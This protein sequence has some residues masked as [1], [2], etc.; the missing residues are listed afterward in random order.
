MPCASLHSCCVSTRRRRSPA[1]AL[2]QV[3]AAVLGVP[4][5]PTIKEVAAD[6]TVVKTLVRAALWE[7]QT[8]QVGPLCRVTC[9]A[10]ARLPAPGE[11]GRGRPC[12]QVACCGRVLCVDG[13]AMQ[14]PLATHSRPAL[15]PHEPV[16]RR[17]AYPARAHTACPLLP[18]PRQVIRPPLLR[19]GFELVRA[20]GL[21]VTDDVSIIEALGEPVR[22]TPGSYTNIKVRAAAAQPQPSTA[23]SSL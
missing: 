13:Q 12:R 7:V 4:V 16:T 6:R 5:K 3:G 14:R 9:Q 22:I 15:Q 2:H 21:E 1:P 19:E 20:Q 17:P 18:R 23:S 11:R 10:A 8:P